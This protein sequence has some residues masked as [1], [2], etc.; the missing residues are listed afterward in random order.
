M[1]KKRPWLVRYQ[2]YGN[3]AVGWPI[4]AFFFCPDSRGLLI[5]IVP[6]SILIFFLSLVVSNER[7]KDFQKVHNTAYDVYIPEDYPAYNEM[8]DHT[9]VTHYYLLIT[10]LITAGICLPFFPLGPVGESNSLLVKNPGSFLALWAVY[11]VFYILLGS[12]LYSGPVLAWKIISDHYTR[13]NPAA[14]REEKIE[15]FKSVVKKNTWKE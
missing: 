9:N 4:L 2:T 1:L 15:R 14:T 8:V 11:I 5:Y 10:M 12:L 7:A 13:I 3:L 6:L